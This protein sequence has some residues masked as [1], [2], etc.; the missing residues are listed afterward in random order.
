M[1]VKYVV[2]IDNASKK[3]ETIPFIGMYK[4]NLKLTLHSEPK[5][6]QHFYSNPAI[7][8]LVYMHAK[9]TY[10]EMD[11]VESLAL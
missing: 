3:K 4:G 10:C 9:L 5:I 6:T 7:S 2:Q 11:L 1:M 8:S